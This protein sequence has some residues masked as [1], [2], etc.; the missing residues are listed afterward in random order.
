M[1]LGW[2]VFDLL[3][4]LYLVP[5]SWFFWCSIRLYQRNSRKEEGEDHSGFLVLEV[6]KSRVVLAKTVLEELAPPRETDRES[7]L[8]GSPVE[9]GHVC[10]L[11]SILFSLS[12][13]RGTGAW[14]DWFWY[15]EDWIFI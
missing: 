6:F 1:D 9:A 7:A 4:S 11:R 10:G 3:D 15:S 12:I 5:G 8:C 2:K 13:I 14:W